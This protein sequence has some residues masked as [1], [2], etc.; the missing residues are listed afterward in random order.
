MY[1]NID[2]P[3]ATNIQMASPCIDTERHIRD[4]SFLT[5]MLRLMARAREKIKYCKRQFDEYTPES[6]P[7]VSRDEWIAEFRKWGYINYRLERYYL[8]KVCELNS[9]TYKAITRE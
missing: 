6:S 5:G 1:A 9:V 2:N 8:K 3:P 4:V 7:F